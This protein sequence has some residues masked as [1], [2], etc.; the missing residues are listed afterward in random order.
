MHLFALMSILTFKHDTLITDYTITDLQILKAIKLLLINTAI[1]ILLLNINKE[2]LLTPLP[3]NKIHSNTHIHPHTKHIKY[4]AYFLG[5]E[6]R[7][8]E[9]L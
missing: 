6:T 5:G 3:L 2:I 7:P 9:V 4:K 1:I 8:S